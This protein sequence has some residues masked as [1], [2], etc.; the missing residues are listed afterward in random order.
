MHPSTLNVQG[1]RTFLPR[2]LLILCLASATAFAADGLTIDSLTG[3]TFG[4]EDD[5]AGQGFS[6]KKKDQALYV[7]WK[8][9]GSGVDV[10]SETEYPVEVKGPKQCVFSPNIKGKRSEVKID[11]SWDPEIRV[12]LDGIRIHV[13][14]LKKP[15]P[16]NPKTSK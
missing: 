4:V 12:Y 8:V 6:F 14:D 1:L 15:E 2:I 7:T 10:V 9:F 13:T 16:K 5:W 11:L 3:R